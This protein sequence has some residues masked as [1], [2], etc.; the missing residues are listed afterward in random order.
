[1]RVSHRL[2]NILGV[3]IEVDLEKGQF[4]TCLRE[5]SI[6]VMNFTQSWGHIEAFRVARSKKPADKS[7]ISES[8]FD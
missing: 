4:R 8:N 5:G 2:S 3:Q 1:M 6:L 7:P